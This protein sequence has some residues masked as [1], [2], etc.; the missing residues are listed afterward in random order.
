MKL[1]LVAGARPNFMKIFPLIWEINNREEIKKQVQYKFVHTGQHYDNQ[2]SDIILRDLGLPAP[3]INLNV[4][5]ASNSVQTAKIMIEFE[6]ICLD[7][8]PNL[9]IVVGDVNSTL[10]CSLVGTRLGI[11]IA[12]VEAGLRSFDRSMPEEINRILTDSI[13]D[14]LFTTCKDANNNLL[15]EGIDREKI[16]FVGNVMIDTLCKFKN[17]AQRN[18]AY[19]AFGVSKKKFAVLTLHR[20]SNVDERGSLEKIL[21]A[22]EKISKIVPVI[23]PVHPRTEALIR[24]YNLSS[25]GNISSSIIFKRPVGYLEFLN[26]M[27]N[28]KFVLTDSGGIQEETTILRIP[29]LT[30]RKNTERPVTIKMGTN[31]LVGDDEDKILANVKKIMSNNYKSKPRIPKYWDGNAARRIVDIIQGNFL[32]RRDRNQ[33]DNSSGSGG[34]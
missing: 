15:S 7:E 33:D 20:P 2:L 25:S 16:H 28:A 11:E 24:D 10:A 29:C 26:L 27:M 9:I 34:I 8:K 23:F 6:G 22:I 3:D 32:R 18:N 1:F 13:S 21:K 4:G 12:H 19:K 14:Y 17:E 30:L 5:S 31:T